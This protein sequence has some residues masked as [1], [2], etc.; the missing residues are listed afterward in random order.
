M[1]FNVH[2]GEG[3][4]SH[5]DVVSA[6]FLGALTLKK[7]HIPS[8]WDYEV[9][10]I[11]RTECICGTEVYT[12]SLA[13]ASKVRLNWLEIKNSVKVHFHSRK[14]STDRTFSENI[15]V[16]SWKFSTSKFFSDWKFVSAN[17]ILQIFLFAENF[18]E[19]KWTFPGFQS[20]RQ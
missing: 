4:Y 8:P 7:P 11:Q 5:P 3:P 1:R 10:S 18:L 9:C 20:L 13:L 2:N 16:K 17:H 15:I 14:F 6:A 12:V 19:W